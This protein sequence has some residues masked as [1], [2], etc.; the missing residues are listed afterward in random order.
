[1]KTVKSSQFQGMDEDILPCMTTASLIGVLRVLT[2]SKNLHARP[3]PSVCRTYRWGTQPVR[4]GARS[5]FERDIH[6]QGPL[7]LLGYCSFEGVIVPKGIF[8]LHHISV[9]TYMTHYRPNDGGSKH[10]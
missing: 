4:P 2:R 7:L 5:V 8:N 3:C 10:L 9:M 6:G 1:M